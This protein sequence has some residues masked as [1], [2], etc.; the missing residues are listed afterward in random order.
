MRGRK[1]IP[2]EF[3]VITGEKRTKR[4]A[5]D[6]PQ[7]D[8]SIPD[9]PDFLDD[10]AQEEW[11]RI[12][13]ELKRMGVLAD[14]DRAALAGY[15]QSYSNWVNAVKK[16]KKAGTIIKTSNGNVIQSPLVG[17]ANKALEMM[18]KFAVEFGMTPSSR[19]RVK[20]T[21]S[22]ESAKNKWSNLG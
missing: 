21:K 5:P 20:A 16:I 6:R 19:S 18:Q 15:C 3:K 11:N 1:P 2:P 9:I 7:P 4:L 14:V 22:D 10:D 12:A 13:P 17:I 8:A